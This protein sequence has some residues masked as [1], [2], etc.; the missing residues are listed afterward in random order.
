MRGLNKKTKAALLTALL[1]ASFS[2]TGCQKKSADADIEKDDTDEVVMSAEPAQDTTPAIVAG[3]LDDA[4]AQLNVGDEVD[5][6]DIVEGANSKE[7]VQTETLQ[8]D[9]V[10]EET[11]AIVPPLEGT[12]DEKSN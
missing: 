1:A 4:D 5:T 10:Q 6:A 2:V 3:D 12:E 9:D 11:Q 7:G 8:T